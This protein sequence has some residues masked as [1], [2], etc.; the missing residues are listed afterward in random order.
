MSKPFVIIASIHVMEDPG[1]EPELCRVY[2]TNAG[3]ATQKAMDKINSTL[4]RK[5][6]HRSFMDEYYRALS[7]A[8]GKP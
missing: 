4:E 8:G 5:R 6:V 2:S 1:F 3:L 7:Q